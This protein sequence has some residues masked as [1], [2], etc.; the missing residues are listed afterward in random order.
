LGRQELHL[1][2]SAEEPSSWGRF[3]R[4]NRRHVI[5]FLVATAGLLGSRRYTAAQDAS[6]PASRFIDVHCHLFNG[7]DVPAAQFVL[8]VVARESGFQDYAQVAA[9]FVRLVAKFA[10]TADEEFAKL[11]AYRVL[12]PLPDEMQLTDTVLRGYVLQTLLDLKSASSTATTRSLATSPLVQELNRAG[13]STPS[14]LFSQNE[15]HL[16]PEG[17]A[18]SFLAAQYGQQEIPREPFSHENRVRGL[19]F[20]VLSLA[21]LEEIAGN[22]VADSAALSSELGAF[23]AFA[24]SFVC[25]RSTNL[26]R[27][28]GT[29]GLAQAR[30]AAL[31]VPLLIDYD[32][33]LGAEDTTPLATQT[34]LLGA[35]SK[36]TKPGVLMNGFAAFDPLRSVISKRE[37][38]NAPTSPMDIVRSAICNDGFIGVK[39]YPPMGFRAARNHEVS[40]FGKIADSWAARWRITPQELGLELDTALKELYGFCLQNDIPILAH[41]SNSQTSF[42]GSGLR[43]APEFWS[44]ALRGSAP[45]HAGPVS[46]ASLRLN[47]AHAGGLWCHSGEPPSSEDERLRCAAPTV[48]H[49][50][51]E[52][53]DLAANYQSVYFDFADMGVLSESPANTQ[54][55]SG[56]LTQILTTPE[57]RKALSTKLLY[58][59][60]WMFLSVAASKTYTNFPQG[61]ATF[62]ER[63][64]AAARDVL[65][66]N[67]ARFLGLTTSG[68]TTARLRD[69]YAGDRDRLSTLEALIVDDGQQPPP[70]AAACPS[71]G[72]PLSVTQPAP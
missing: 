41:C 45:G 25:Y 59:T 67:T 6:A 11:A 27:L 21:H 48:S 46:C 8:H 34:K 31:Y 54:I 17:K 62:S 9:F 43:A 33:W 51:E 63:F 61:V 57:R 14:N 68:T 10:P 30:V 49:W 56:Y 50:P 12:D 58:G 36:R 40:T 24:K 5:A 38:R 13:I 32:S 53:L 70:L 35:I 44:S 3:V 66:T 26:E 72:Q 52:I 64:G 20:S 15:V 4:P 60:D 69:Y 42:D 37:S 47:L 55:L 7:R 19:N 71:V 18:L 1:G 39:L 16:N 29:F 23:L 65:W 28:D 2:W 22:I